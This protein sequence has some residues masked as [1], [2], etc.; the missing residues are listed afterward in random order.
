MDTH[1]LLVQAALR[2][3]LAPSSVETAPVQPQQA[4]DARSLNCLSQAVYYEARGETYQGQVAVAEVVINRLHSKAY[5]KTVCDVVYQGSD[6]SI[7]CQFTF[8]CDGSIDRR[9][10]GAA[11]TRAQEIA[12]QVLGGYARPMIGRAT[13][14]HTNAVDPLWSS[15]MIETTRIGSHIFYRFPN[16]S[17]RPLA[18]QALMLRRHAGVAADDSDDDDAPAAAQPELIPQAPQ[19]AAQAEAI[20]HHAPS[21]PA[22]TP[23][24]AP[25]S[26]VST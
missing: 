3:P 11:W 26:E 2:G 10:R 25:N 21:A 5:P 18:Q 7:G 6:R 24:T 9:P 1:A 22:Q 14:Y 19:A 17:E 12:N 15:G 4:I 8:T 20:A 13:H 16:E 23:A